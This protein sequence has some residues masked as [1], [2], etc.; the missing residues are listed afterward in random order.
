[1]N[2]TGIESVYRIMSVFAL[3]GLLLFGLFG[4][5]SG[6]QMSE[7]GM[8]GN[9]PFTVGS[10]ICNMGVFEHMKMWQSMLNSLPQDLALSLLLLSLSFIFF[11]VYRLFL[12][13]SEDNPSFSSEI[14]YREFQVSYFHNILQSAFSQGILHSKL[15]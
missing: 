6:M 12:K 4:M 5:L 2:F 10:A 7:D 9:C 8:I 14:Y 15:Y 13:P 1:M 11:V 3:A